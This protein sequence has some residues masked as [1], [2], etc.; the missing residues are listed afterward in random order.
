MDNPVKLAT[1]DTNKTKTQHNMC[2]TP[3]ANKHK[4]DM[5]PCCTVIIHFDYL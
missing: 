2:W 4:Q 1:L 3:H 5:S